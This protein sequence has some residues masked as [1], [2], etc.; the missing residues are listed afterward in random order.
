MSRVGWI[1]IDTL[2]HKDEAFSGFLVV[3]D[4]DSKR[5]GLALREGRPNIGNRIEVFQLYL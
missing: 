5:F 4:H 2:Y 1:I 3:G